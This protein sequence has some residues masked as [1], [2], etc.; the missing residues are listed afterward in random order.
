MSDAALW[1]LAAVCG[2]L[3]VCGRASVA[4]EQRAL[5]DLS[6]RLQPVT[7]HAAGYQPCR[8]D[9]DLCDNITVICENDTVTKLFAAACFF[10]F[11]LRTVRCGGVTGF[12]LPRDGFCGVGAGYLR[13]SG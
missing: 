13:E 3:A 8:A 5:C 4:A 11:A 12:C 6:S 1:L 7:W 2:A 10:C 9:V